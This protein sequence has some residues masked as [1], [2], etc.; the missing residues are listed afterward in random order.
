MTAEGAA[1]TSITGKS[2]E[3]IG[4][5]TTAGETAVTSVLNA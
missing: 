4:L 1:I 5:I 2:D 3:V